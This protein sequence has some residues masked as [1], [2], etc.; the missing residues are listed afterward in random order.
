MMR[1]S[2]AASPEPLKP[3]ACEGDA[4]LSPPTVP[5]DPTPASAALVAPGDL[6]ARPPKCAKSKVRRKGHCLKG[7]APKHRSNHSRRAAR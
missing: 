4:C 3:P 7:K 1:A 5:N 6:G 2:T